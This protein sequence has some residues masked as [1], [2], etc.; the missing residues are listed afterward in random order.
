[1]KPSTAEGDANSTHS[2]VA[3]KTYRLRLIN[4]AFNHQFV[5]SIDNHPMTVITAD[6]VPIQPKTGVTQVTL[7][8]GQ[9]YDILFTANQAASNYWM[10]V[11]PGCVLGGVADV[12]NSQQYQNGQIVPGAILHYST[13]P[14]ANPTSTA[15]SVTQTCNDD[16][17]VPYWAR[18]VP[19]SGFNAGQLAVSQGTVQRNPGGTLVAWFINNSPQYAPWGNPTLAQVVAG[20]TTFPTS[21]NVYAITGSSTTWTYWVIQYASGFGP[22]VA[23]PVHLHGHNF[24][25]LGSGSGTFGGGTSGLNFA[26]AP[27]RDT[28]MLP[29]G[30]WLVVAFLLDNPGAWLMHCH[31]AWHVSQGFSLQFLE[32]ES[33]IQTSIPAAQFTAMQQN[34]NNWN[35]YAPS[36]PYP[37]IDSG[38]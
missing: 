32:N 12:Y 38:L 37:E 31:I 8:P 34:C 30:G 6:W 11:K 10:R 27:R 29:A 22:P 35:A 26:T 20:Q 36:S 15:Y 16:S 23:H 25:V 28:A 1:M 4:A 21:E 19:S 7:G 24:Y 14:V 9:R 5:F 3:G 33:K 18:T 2:V 13:A 17:V